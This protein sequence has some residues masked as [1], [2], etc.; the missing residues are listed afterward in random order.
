MGQSIKYDIRRSGAID[1]DRASF[2][3]AHG[4]SFASQIEREDVSVRDFF[5]NFKQRMLVSPAKANMSKA[6]AHQFFNY[7]AADIAAGTS[8]AN[9]SF[10]PA[11]YDLH[12]KT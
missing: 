10:P 9:H 2:A 12:P 1:Y 5:C 8:H 7:E 4:V 6:H 11:M 3:E